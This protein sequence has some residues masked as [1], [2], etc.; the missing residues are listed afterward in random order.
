MEQYINKAAIVAEV[1]FDAFGV[2][3]EHL[4]ACDAHG[5]T[6]KYSD[7]ELDLLEKIS[8]NKIQKVE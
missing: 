5:V 2:L 8:S 7:R 3:A 1:D 6:P 4:L